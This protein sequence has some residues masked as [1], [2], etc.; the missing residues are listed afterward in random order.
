MDQCREA[1]TRVFLHP[2]PHVQYRAAGGVDEDAANLT[3]P[4][5]VLRGHAERRQDHHVL[6]GDMSEVEGAGLVRVE[7]PNSHFGHA[8]IHVGVVNDL[9]H[10]V[11]AA[12]GK[13]V[14]RLVR[15]ID[16]SVDSVAE[17]ELLGEA[18][19]D[20]PERVRV[21]PRA[22]ALDQGGVVC[23]VDEG[24]DLGLEA[25]ALAEVGLFHRAR[26]NRT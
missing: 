26:S 1:I 18:H 17:A 8:P 24:F 21:A 23:G 15:V 9:T 20:V 13:L 3:Q 12:V 16:G 4:L 19:C 5:E 2:L 25:E 14:D 10:Q 6:R 11:D 7:E 22:N